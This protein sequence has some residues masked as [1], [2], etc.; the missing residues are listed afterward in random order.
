MNNHH[1]DQCIYG[2]ICPNLVKKVSQHFVIDETT[3]ISYIHLLEE[4]ASIEEYLYDLDQNEA[5]SDNGKFA[6]AILMNLLK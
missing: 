5:F 4:P 1:C 2:Q 6:E 3:A